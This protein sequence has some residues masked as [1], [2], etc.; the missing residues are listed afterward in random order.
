MKQK[1]SHFKLSSSF[2][3]LFTTKNT[4][5]N[6]TTR[7]RWNH[8]EQ[9]P[10][11]STSADKGLFKLN[12]RI[13]NHLDDVPVDV[14]RKKSRTK[15]ESLKDEAQSKKFSIF[16]EKG[17]HNPNKESLVSD[18]KNQPKKCISSF[19]LDNLEMGARKKSKQ[20]GNEGEG[21]P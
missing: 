6:P 14:L 19:K 1:D 10:T 4:S 21:N 20:K 18:K 5:S 2:K 8:A 15:L 16:N 17:D 13:A 9:K 3:T 11:T 12:P 7:N